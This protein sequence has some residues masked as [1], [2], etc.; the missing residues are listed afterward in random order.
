MGGCLHLEHVNKTVE[1]GLV[2]GV[3]EL[4]YWCEF[5][6]SLLYYLVRDALLFLLLHLEVYK[7]II[8]WW[9]NIGLVLGN[10]KLLMI[11]GLSRRSR[12]NGLLGAAP[13]R[14]L[15][16]IG[17]ISWRDDASKE[18]W[19]WEWPWN[20]CIFLSFPL[21][22]FRCLP[23]GMH[24]EGDRSRYWSKGLVS[25]LAETWFRIRYQ[26]LR[27]LRLLQVWSNLQRFGLNAWSVSLSRRIAADK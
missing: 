18:R 19:L 20:V 27:A 23:S 21:V 2:A 17:L 16:V 25:F 3:W 1:E 8:S 6:P 4:I 9:G 12:W 15:L 14:F 13:W 26:F 22:S 10:I 5:L 7:N 24:R 11:K